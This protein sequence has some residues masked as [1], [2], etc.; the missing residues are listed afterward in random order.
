M[1]ELSLRSLV[2]SRISRPFR[3]VRI[4]SSSLSRIGHIWA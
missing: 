2:R 3:L 1:G 4:L